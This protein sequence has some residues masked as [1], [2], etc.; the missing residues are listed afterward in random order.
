MQP[1]ASDLTTMTRLCPYRVDH[2]RGRKRRNASS[3]CRGGRQGT[4][5]GGASL[6]SSSA[7]RRCILPLSPSM[8]APESSEL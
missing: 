6:A 1:V 4:V 8:A 3:S 7:R 5:P 2:Y